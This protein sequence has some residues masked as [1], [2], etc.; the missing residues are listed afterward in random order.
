[1]EGRNKVSGT[2]VLVTVP[3]REGVGR[4]FVCK[5]VDR[6]LPKGAVHPLDVFELLG[7]RSGVDAATIE[8]CAAW[9][10]FYQRYLARDWSATGMALEAFTATWGTDPLTRIYAQRIARFKAEPP[11]VDSDGVIRYSTK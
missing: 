3:V 7:E 11:A 1:M 2:P 8:R 4:R 5:P 9:S 6:V 10:A